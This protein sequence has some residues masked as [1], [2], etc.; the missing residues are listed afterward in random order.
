M[1][2]RLLPDNGKE[3]GIYAAAFRLY[4]AGNMF[5]FLFASLLLPMFAAN[6]K[7]TDRVFDLSQSALRILLPFAIVA[8]LTTSF[9]GK[10][11]WNPSI[12]KGNAYYGEV[13]AILM[14]GFFCVSLSYIYGTLVTATENLK[15]FNISFG[16]GILINWSL[17]F[18]LI[19]EYQALGAA[20]ATLVTQVFIIASQLILAHRLTKIQI[21]TNLILRTVVSIAIS[22]LIFYGFQEFDEH[23]SWYLILA[24]SI[25]FSLIISF[26]VGL[27]RLDF[28]SMFINDALQAKQ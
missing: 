1:L 9:M 2:E 20:Y 5:A 22:I 19:P 16:I 21:N 8:V 10:R 4:E 7:K 26:L 27:L 18:C 25:I 13:L 14:F 3:A 15:W 12:R 17:N 6:L 24:F 23:I 28:A 11:L